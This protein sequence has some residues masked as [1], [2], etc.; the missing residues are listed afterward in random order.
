MG[1]EAKRSVN[2][3]VEEH[4]FLAEDHS[5]CNPILCTT[6]ATPYSLLLLVLLSMGSAAAGHDYGEALSKSI[7]FYEA[8]RSGKLPATQRASW[9]ADS[10]L[11]DGFANGVCS[12]SLL[13]CCVQCTN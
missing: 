5:C 4:K 3:V 8:Q 10:G 7:L 1:P 9:R 13:I 2:W 11:H 6:M 12:F